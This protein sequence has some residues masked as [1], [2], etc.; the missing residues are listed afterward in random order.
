MSL[1]ARQTGPDK[2]EVV[3][4][5]KKKERYKEKENERK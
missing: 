5:V 3:L 4:C 1:C 2:E